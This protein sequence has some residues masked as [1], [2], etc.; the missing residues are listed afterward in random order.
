MVTATKKKRGRPKKAEKAAAKPRDVAA[1]PR[2]L[3]LIDKETGEEINAPYRNKAVDDAYMERSQMKRRIAL[4][5]AKYEELDERFQ[6]VLAVEQ[7]HISEELGEG[8]AYTTVDALNNL[9]DVKLEQGG[10]RLYD[11]KS[12][13]K[14]AEN[15]SE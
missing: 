2:Q 1:D 7:E 11:K 5:Q 14:W 12:R 9:R 10:M 6:D 15:G 8:V 4:N 13:F 3:H